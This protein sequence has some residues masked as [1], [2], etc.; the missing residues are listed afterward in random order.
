MVVTFRHTPRLKD[1]PL[2]ISR[3]VRLKVLETTLKAGVL[4]FLDLV[5]RLV[6]INWLKV[7]I[8]YD[9]NLPASPA[10][11]GERIYS[12]DPNPQIRI[13]NTPIFIDSDGFLGW[14]CVLKICLSGSLTIHQTS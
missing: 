4:L 1:A 5:F 11:R 13:L 8:K 14:D 6:L 10:K 7:G 3:L 2:G 9:H 12:N